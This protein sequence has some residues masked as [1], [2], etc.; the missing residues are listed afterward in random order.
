MRDGRNKFFIAVALLPPRSYKYE[1]QKDKDNNNIMVKIPC[2]EKGVIE[3]MV[4]GVNPDG[5]TYTRLTTSILEPPATRLH[6]TWLQV[7]EHVEKSE[8]AYFYGAFRK[9][10]IIFDLKTDTLIEAKGAGAHIFGSLFTDKML[11]SEELKITE[12]WR[13]YIN[14]NR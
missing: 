2:D 11:N 1:R 9:N 10:F 8:A 4:L 5:R 7:T 3:T 13:T 6:S 14:K 12:T